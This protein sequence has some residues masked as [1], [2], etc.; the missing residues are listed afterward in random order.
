MSVETT[1]LKMAM[2]AT[3]AD[4]LEPPLIASAELEFMSRSAPTTEPLV[5]EIEKTPEHI[6]LLMLCKTRDD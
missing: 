1:T 5:S 2:E 4:N 3:T 6:W